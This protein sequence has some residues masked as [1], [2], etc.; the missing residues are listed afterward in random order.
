MSDLQAVNGSNLPAEVS[1]WGEQ[2]IDASNILL[3]RLL[4]MQGLSELV[5]EGK[6]KL[7]DVVKN[8]SGE[9]IATKDKPVEFI[10]LFHVEN[11]AISEQVGSKYEWRRNEPVNLSNR[12]AELEFMHQGTKWRR[13]RCLDFFVI[14]SS[15]VAK[16][17]KA[18]AAIAKGEVPDVDSAVFPC[19]LSFR[20]T[21]IAAGKE[22]VK[23]FATAKHFKIAPS[24]WTFKLTCKVDKNDK[25]TYAVFGIEKAGTTPKE[26]LP[27]CKSWYDIITASAAKVKIHDGEEVAEESAP[28]DESRSKF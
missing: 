7:G 28:I 13:D 20:R 12:N 22:L 17:K 26:Y 9:V 4:L 21:S 18:R 3:P 15:D 10:P 19:Y 2:E 16:E 25:G 27:L 23:A 5:S 24:A 6:A 14:L 8:T 1:S 11:W